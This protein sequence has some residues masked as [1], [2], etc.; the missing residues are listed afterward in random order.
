[1]ALRSP[2]GRDRTGVASESSSKD[3]C[4][5]EERLRDGLK[6]GTIGLLRRKLWTPVDTGDVCTMELR[7]LKPSD[8]ATF[9]KPLPP[10]L[11]S[12][13]Y[14]NMTGVELPAGA[15]RAIVPSSPF[16]TGSRPNR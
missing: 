4:R 12:G 15:A 5:G 13:E 8:Q 3:I 10:N 7:F 16:S 9:T 14:R 11:G 6:A 1:M 2:R